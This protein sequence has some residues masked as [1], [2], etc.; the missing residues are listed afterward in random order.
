MFALPYSALL[1][2]HTDF[3]PKALDGCIDLALLINQPYSSVRFGV[4]VPQCC[5]EIYQITIQ[6]AALIMKLKISYL[7]SS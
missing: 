3:S 2:S 6:G 1:G 4:S 5:L 7:K